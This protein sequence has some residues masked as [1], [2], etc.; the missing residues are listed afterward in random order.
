MMQ[1]WKA[2]LDFLM[3]RVGDYAKQEKR[4]PQVS[5]LL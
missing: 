3:E 1:D 2:Y 4:G 5:E